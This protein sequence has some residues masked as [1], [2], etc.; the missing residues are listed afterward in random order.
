METPKIKK[1][2]D[3]ENPYKIRSQENNSEKD[4]L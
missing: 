4:H 3:M 1:R 2:K